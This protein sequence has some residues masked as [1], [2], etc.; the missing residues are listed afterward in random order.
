MKTDQN[1]I[2]LVSHI[3]E[4]YILPDYKRWAKSDDRR[5]AAKNFAE[6]YRRERFYLSVG[7]KWRY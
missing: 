2:L 6:P 7:K 4:A 1:S 5:R 3:I